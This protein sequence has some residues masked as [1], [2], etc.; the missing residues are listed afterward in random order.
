MTLDELSTCIKRLKRGKN[1]GING[2]LADMTK[3]GGNLLKEC[4]LWLLNRI[5]GSHL[6]GCLS[7]GHVTAV[8]KSGDK[9][10]MSNY[11]GI[12]DRN[13]LASLRPCAA[14]SVTPKQMFYA[15]DHEGC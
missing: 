14:A 15:R 10:S 13:F 8:Y 5:L 4:L 2:V 12:F 11:R 7:V 3:D 9:N 1:P 6:P